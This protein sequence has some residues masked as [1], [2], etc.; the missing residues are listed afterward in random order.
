MLLTK[1][2]PYSGYN[3]IDTFPIFAFGS[4][5][6]YLFTYLFIKN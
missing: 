5:Y 4:E 2:G 3:S 6:Y 1:Q